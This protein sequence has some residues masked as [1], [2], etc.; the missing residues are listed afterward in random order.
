[1]AYQTGE[2]NLVAHAV[3]AGQG[4][5]VW[6]YINSDG[7]TAATMR[8]TDFVTDGE[9]KGMKVND[10]V[11]TQDDSNVGLVLVANA[12]DADGNVTLT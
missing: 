2:L 10:I 5:S 1:M 3:G 8:G 12:I 7:D 11:L 9:D 4:G 6:T